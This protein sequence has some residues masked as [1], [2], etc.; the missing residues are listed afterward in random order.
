MPLISGLCMLTSSPLLNAF[1]I[2]LE[3]KGCGIIFLPFSLPCRVLNLTLIRR[4]SFCLFG[5]LLVLKFLEL[6]AFLLNT[7]STVFSVS[8][9][10]LPIKFSIMEGIIVPSLNWSSAMF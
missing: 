4:L 1:C 8:A 5:H 2:A 9:T 3:L 10:K 7:F 6:R